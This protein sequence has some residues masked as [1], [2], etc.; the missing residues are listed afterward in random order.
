MPAA[1]SSVEVVRSGPPRFEAQREQKAAL[2][3]GGK[4]YFGGAGFS[5]LEAIC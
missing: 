4:N 2:H 1:W 3:I 5:R